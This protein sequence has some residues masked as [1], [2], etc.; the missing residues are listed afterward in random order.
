MPKGH[1]V[2]PLTL[3]GADDGRE[4]WAWHSSALTGLLAPREG[5]YVVVI[6]DTGLCTPM[7]VL[8]GLNT[9]L[10]FFFFPA[11]TNIARHYRVSWDE[12]NPLDRGWRRSRNQARNYPN[13]GLGLGLG[14]HHL[15]TDFLR[16]KRFKA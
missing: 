10:F 7:N 5:C 15:R 9:D 3:H 2:L 1:V 13:E 11:E 6:W 16:L 8:P 14:L 12:I 4:S